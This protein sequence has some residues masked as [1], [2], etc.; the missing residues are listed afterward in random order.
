MHNDS[1]TLS[2]FVLIASRLGV[3]VGKSELFRRFPVSGTEPSLNELTTIA[4]QFGLK[5]KVMKLRPEQLGSLKNSF[6]VLLRVMGDKAVILEGVAS[7]TAGQLVATVRDPLTER[8]AETDLGHL[9]DV[10][11]GTAVLFKRET[12]ARDANEP[13]GNSWIWGQV[14]KEKKHFVE[15]AVAALLG[16]IF[17]I[18]PPLMFMAVVNRVLVNNS[19][20]T[21]KVFVVLMFLLIIFESII[22][23]ARR[24]TMEVVV[25]RID[26]RLNLYMLNRVLKLP[27]EYFEKNATGRTMSRLNRMWVIRNFLTGQLFGAFVDSVPLLGII[28]ILFMLNWRLALFVLVLS[29]L[30]FLIVLAYLKPVAKRFKK[31]VLAE[32]NKGAH[33]IETLNGIRTIKSLALE[34]RRQ[35]EWDT[36]T[37]EL[38]QTKYD[39]GAISN[40]PQTLTTPLERL[41]QKG[42][43]LLGAYLALTSPDAMTAGT[44]G[45]FVMLASRVSA[46]LVQLAKLQLTFAELGGAMSELEAVLNSPPEDG[47]EISGVRSPI[48]GHLEFKSVSF[49]YSPASS[50]VLDNLSFELQSGTSLGV[51]GRSGSGKTTLTR[52]LQGLHKSYEGL[53]KIDGIELKDYSL[54][55]LRS[56]IGIVLQENFLFSGTIRDNVAIAH[57]HAA[58]EDVVRVCQLAG[59][60]EFIERLPRGYDTRLEEGATNLSG[61]QRQRLAIARALLSNPSFLIFDEATSALDAESETIVNE[62]LRSISEGRTVICVSHRLS[63]L[64]KFDRIMVMD[65]GKIYDIGTHKELLER[66]DI[67]AHLWHQQNRG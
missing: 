6:P 21:L 10:W 34:G 2:A 33:L 64:T 24:R 38:T 23:H 65:R 48:K 31:V 56:S 8:V 54:S 52:L 11:D 44:I 57:P 62:N 53:I 26:A 30:V 14:F 66:C 15:I 18:A 1:T 5:C 40:W 39:L 12:T 61:G 59:A 4:G 42:T 49:R 20:E 58:F 55:H 41:M 50:M 67:Y 43:L 13:F 16:T 27:I 45:A 3:Q 63:M 47:N 25:A 28:P 35:K 37:A 46:P 60:E 36:I 22:G 17:T 9:S 19:M 29:V 32:Q 51:V 7:N